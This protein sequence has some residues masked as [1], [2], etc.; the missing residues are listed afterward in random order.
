ME[1]VVEGSELVD[2]IP[3]IP[4]AV[5]VEPL[6][7]F[8]PHASKP[9]K[10]SRFSFRSRSLLLSICLCAVGDARAV[11]INTVYFGQSH[12]LKATARKTHSAGRILPPPF[13]RRNQFPPGLGQDAEGETRN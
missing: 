2:A 3:R 9:V 10:I 1:A 7:P 4:M 5:S 11:T 13:Q 12:L 6:P 8:L